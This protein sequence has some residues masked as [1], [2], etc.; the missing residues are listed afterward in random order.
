MIPALLAL[1][2]GAAGGLV[3]RE[4][5]LP[6]PW[7]L[8][9][10]A[11]NLL[12]SLF[13]ARPKMPAHLR[14]VMV[15]VLGLMLG[16]AFS[17]AMLEQVGR[18]PAGMAAVLAYVLLGTGILALSFRRLAGYDPATAYFSAA[19]GGLTEMILTGTAMGGDERTISLT[20]ALR[21]VLVV[22]TVP[23]AFRLFGGYQGGG[24][25]MPASLGRLADLNATDA[26]VLAAC[27]V[28][29]HLAA[30]AIRMPAAALTGP[31]LASAALHLSGL[32]ESHPPA[33]L[34]AAAQVVVGAAIGARFA[35]IRKEG[36]A[37]EALAA[38]AATALLLA[39]TLGL[40]WATADLSGLPIAVLIL[41]LA[42][43][44]LA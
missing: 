14:A 36:I 32:T 24:G 11:A 26:A 30:R 41:A 22:F 39:L 10:L 1:G 16:S 18:W 44:G 31:M 38:I 2:L 9:A 25:G 13:G 15:G 35:T 12:A 6:L 34:V 37:R 43:G 33:E 4:I 17:P 21:I 40:A 27:A 19:P 5:G 3:F 23:F 42:P 20:H 28:A 29:G 8:G 7:M